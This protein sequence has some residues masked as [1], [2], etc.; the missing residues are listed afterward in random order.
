MGAP[1]T[2]SAVGKKIETDARRSGS[3]LG[4]T[5]PAL[6]QNGALP[7]QGFPRESCIGEVNS[8]TARNLISE[9]FVK[10]P[11]LQRPAPVW[12]KRVAKLRCQ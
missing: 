8:K 11:I 3:W 9:H 5:L 4:E 7:V 12:R 1:S 10:Q 2:A 6:W